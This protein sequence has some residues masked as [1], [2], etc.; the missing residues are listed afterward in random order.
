[1]IHTDK[2]VVVVFASTVF[3][4]A[5]YLLMVGLTGSGDKIPAAGG[6]PT[7]TAGVYLPLVSKMESKSGP[8]E[9]RIGIR[10]VDGVGEFYDQVTGEKFVPRGNNYIRLA[11]QRAC[12]E[13]GVFYHSTFNPGLYQPTRAEQALTKMQQ[14]GYNL[15]R[16]FINHLCVVEPTGRLSNEY[17][18]NIT[19]F[20]QR[21]RTKNIFVMFAID[22]PPV[23]GYAE[24]IPHYPDIDWP[25]Q[26]FLTREGIE[27]ERRF[28]RDF[29][30][31]LI[32]Q[33]A[34][35]DAVLA[36]GLRNEAFFFS[37]RRPLTLTSGLVT[38]GNG[39]TYD[40][41]KP[42][43]KRRMLD[44]N[45]VYWIDQVRT[46]ILEVDPTALVTAGFFQPQEPHPTRVGDPRVIRTRPAIWESSADFIDLHAYPGL[47][48]TMAQYVEN[49]EIA[50]FT[51][52][53]IIMGEFGA[54]RWAYPS[55]EA[56][57]GALQAWQA[58]SCQYGFDGWLL[59]TWDTDETSTGET[60][61]LFN[62]L[63]GD[64]DINRALAPMNRPD[65][66]A[67]GTRIK[68]NVALGKRT[69]A[70]DFLP[71]ERSE[72]AV[73]GLVTTQWGSGNFAPQWL[74]IDLGMP[75]DISEIALLVAQ[76]PEGDT[77]HQVWGQAPGES[78]QLLIE[79]SGHTR[80]GDWLVYA[81]T[82]PWQGVQ[83]IRI[84]TIA[85]PSWV[86]WKEIWLFGAGE[87][88]RKG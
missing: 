57:A 4:M 71:D 35:L 19:D 87:R 44:E 40:M 72:M 32:G 36:Y 45:L 10:L 56:A 73:D 77:T 1:M 48:L 31:G 24:S 16:V 75:T 30:L 79:F 2:R 14:E 62:G 66:C 43:D 67:L 61:E 22:D 53:P 69:T 15:V 60:P 54:F 74:E 76:Y 46:A 25:N 33:E 70:S 82:T 6:T 17:L 51:R 5:I 12:G 29:I 65:S 63:S 83:F 85:S 59:W 68:Q 11:D 58:E 78:Y 42:E 8:S 64:G 28:W 80:E 13:P 27:A 47:E 41:A 81:P 34:P 23:P 52:K 38:T 9:H 21:A 18:R 49:F 7:P 37:D 26:K 50:G 88:R 3:V 20:L 39:W 84:E 55:L 86:S